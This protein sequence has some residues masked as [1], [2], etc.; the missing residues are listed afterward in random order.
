M[1][2]V[3]KVTLLNMYYYYLIT[4]ESAT[5]LS[6]LRITVII[7][8]AVCQFTSCCS[9]VIFYNS[10]TGWFL[11]KDDHSCSMFHLRQGDRK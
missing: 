11:G 10:S 7:N 3:S 1:A 9:I 8:V 4:S 5:V 2:N 6:F